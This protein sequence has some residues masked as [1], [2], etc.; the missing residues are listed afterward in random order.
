MPQWKHEIFCEDEE[1]LEMLIQQLMLEFTKHMVIP[2]CKYVFEIKQKYTG[3]AHFYNWEHE[4]FLQK[5]EG[6]TKI[7]LFKISASQNHLP[8]RIPCGEAP[9]HCVNN[10]TKSQKKKRRKAPTREHY[11]LVQGSDDGIKLWR[12]FLEYGNALDI[13]GEVCGPVHSTQSH[14]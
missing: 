6:N 8:D 11:L 14:R 3:A 13:M 10:E 12:D 4:V 1:K 7:P 5:Q 2:F 9:R